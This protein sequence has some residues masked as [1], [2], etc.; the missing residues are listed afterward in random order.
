M[1]RSRAARIVRIESSSSLPP[2]I[3]PPIAHVPSPM[4]DARVPIPWISTCSIVSC[5][6]SLAL[7][8]QTA[9]PVPRETAPHAARTGPDPP[10][11]RRNLG[12][13]RHLGGVT[14]RPPDDG[15]Q[16]GRAPTRAQRCSGLNVGDAVVDAA[17]LVTD[18]LVSPR[19]ARR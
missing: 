12:T 14:I 5:L 4:R 15:P 7:A 11:W 9:S 16:P 1:P 8:A 2:H 19:F 6:L 10:G 18:G 17:D 3:Q 13:C